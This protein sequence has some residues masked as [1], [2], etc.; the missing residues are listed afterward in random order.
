M[1]GIVALRS[2]SSSSSSSSSTLY[3]FLSPHLLR[4]PPLAQQPVRLHPNRPRDPQRPAVITSTPQGQTPETKHQTL[5]GTKQ[6]APFS[7][8]TRKDRRQQDTL[9]NRSEK[10]PELPRASQSRPHRLFWARAAQHHRQRVQWP[11]W[12]GRKRVRGSSGHRVSS[13]R[14]TA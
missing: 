3:T 11:L 8:E 14:S 5:A 1:R 10:P 13:C 9:F 2:F 7:T 4:R 12:R 6:N